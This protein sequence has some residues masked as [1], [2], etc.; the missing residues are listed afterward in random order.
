MLALG[1]GVGTEDRAPPPSCQPSLSI[2]GP[3]GGVRGSLGIQKLIG[4]HRNSPRTVIPM[5]RGILKA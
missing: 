2:W 5:R 3:S 1:A 4:T